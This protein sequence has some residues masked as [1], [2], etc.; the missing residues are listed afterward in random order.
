[1]I[2]WH[3]K[4]GA[5]EVHG[6]I[7][8]KWSNLGWETLGYPLTDETQTADG[9]GRYNHF[10]NGSIYWHPETGAH[11]INGAVESKWVALG[12]D[13]GFLGYPV[14]DT[15]DG[16]WAQGRFSHFQKGSIFW[17]PQLGAHVVQG[18]IRKQWASLGWEGGSLGYPITDEKSIPSSKTRYSQFQ[19]GAIYW[20]P[21]VGTHVTNSFMDDGWLFDFRTNITPTELRSHVMND[22]GLAWFQEEVAVV[23]LEELEHV[24][25]FCGD[26]ARSRYGASGLWCSE[27]A[28]WVLQTAEMDDIYYVQNAFNNVYLHEVT[29]TA[30][31]VM[32]FD[33]NGKRFKW[34]KYGQVTPTTAQP[35][36]YISLTTDGKKKNHSALVVAVTYGG[37]YLWIAEGN[38]DD[39]LALR[40][41][42]F[43]KDGKLAAD[44]DGIGVLDS[45]LFGYVGKKTF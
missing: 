42:D 9:A 43:I 1:V 33:Q 41:I 34:S 4:F 13:A 29:L 5:Y 31:L 16:S 44:I 32:L 7:K 39:C 24:P 22:N 11:M 28:A 30:E 2:F 17:H 10:Q 12:A 21:A 20:H 38:N 15:V 36:D 26:V 18:A 35:G 19:Y 8:T 45:G 37:E 14:S 3:P 25:L 23:A 40:R 6:G 27:F